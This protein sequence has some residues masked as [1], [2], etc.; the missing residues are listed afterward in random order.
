MSQVIE[1]K[2]DLLPMHVLQNVKENRTSKRE[3]KKQQIVNYIVEDLKHKPTVGKGDVASVTHACQ[4]VENMVKKKD[5]IDKL[6]LVIMVFSKIFQHLQP[7]E[8]DLI[9]GFVQFALDSK[10]VKRVST[11]AQTYYFV[12][13][14][15]IN[16]FLFRDA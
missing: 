16:N 7:A 1:P 5:K 2:T 10:L 6:E 8:I 14:V 12:R 4:L 9:K 3:K 11:Y 13:K 15:I